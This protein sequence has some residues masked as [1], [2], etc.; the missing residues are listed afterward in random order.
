M[1]TIKVCNFGK[2]VEMEYYF[3]NKATVAGLT[4]P[5]FFGPSFVTSFQC[6]V[7]GNTTMTSRELAFKYS[8][9]YG[10]VA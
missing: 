7:H 4:V 1:Q 3:N 9:V 6:I 2:F 5:R 10:L 8:I